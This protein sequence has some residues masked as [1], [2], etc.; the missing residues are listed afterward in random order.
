MTLTATKG[1]MLRVTNSS[2]NRD[3]ESLF[4]GQGGMN[5]L[6]LTKL[7]G[8]TKLL[9]EAK[10]LQQTKR[11][12]DLAVAVQVYAKRQK[13]GE[14]AVRY[15]TEIKFDALRKLGEML[16]AGRE[17]G[18]LAKPG[19]RRKYSQKEYLV[20]LGI[21]AKVSHLAQV[22]AGVPDDCFQAAK[23]EQN[24]VGE[25][26]KIHYSIKRKEQKAEFR[27][28][29]Y[30]NHSDERHQAYEEAKA[31]EEQAW[32]TLEEARERFRK[33]LKPFEDAYEQASEEARQTWLALSTHV[34]I[35]ASDEP[36]PLLTLDDAAAAIENGHYDWW[37]AAGHPDPGHLVSKFYRQY[38]RPGDDMCTEGPA[39]KFGPESPGPEY[40]RWTVSVTTPG[41]P[42][43]VRCFWLRGVSEP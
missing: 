23:L 5:D 33:A 19:D 38:C 3:P 26:Y 37:R 13:L 15:A 24:P 22:I 27:E 2:T 14:D 35:G 6:I 31:R 10:T 11:V 4:T 1:A 17:N 25:I 20:D 30:A 39:W 32:Q 12:V 36:C 7:N 21:D 28:T 29:V 18:S 41:Q 16:K 34:L 9:A 42:R 8:A 43:W 40:H